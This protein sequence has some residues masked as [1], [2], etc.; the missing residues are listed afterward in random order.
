MAMHQLFEFARI[1]IPY[2]SILYFP[3]AILLLWMMMKRRGV[4]RLGAACVFAA[5]TLI[6]YGRFIEPRLLVTEE[7]EIVLKR[8]F[9]NAGAVR[10]AVFSDLHLSPYRYAVPVERIVSSVNA[11]NPD[12]VLIPGDFVSYLPPEKFDETFAAL[13]DIEAPVYAVL[14]NHDLGLP[15]PDIAAPLRDSLERLGVSMM[16]DRAVGISG[17]GFDIELVGVSDLWAQNQ[18]LEL[19]SEPAPKARLALTHNPETME[20]IPVSQRPDLLIAGHTHGGQI[21][22][23]FLTCGVTFA[24]RVARY[25]YRE[26]E[27]GAVFVTS[28]TGQS[29]LP[30]RFRVP[31][32]IDILNVE[33]EAC[34]ADP[35]LD[36]PSVSAM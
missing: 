1:V 17:D 27:G 5:L 10:L 19:F 35:G 29:M 8:C 18:K 26:M 30:M 7:H 4:L 20:V 36:R 24:C 31:P 21:N 11:A 13:G 3:A 28:G 14:G 25:G 23:P 33:Y 32:R 12:L 22:L 34:P 15:G 6:A 9:P 2:L 16:D